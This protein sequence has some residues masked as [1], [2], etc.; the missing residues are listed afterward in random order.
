MKRVAALCLVFSFLSFAQAGIRAYNQNVDVEQFDRAMIADHGATFSHDWG[1]GIDYPVRNRNLIVCLCIC[2]FL[3]TALM[4]RSLT[5]LLLLLGVYG[6][7]ILLIY[8]WITI[9]LRDLSLNPYYMADSP[10]LLRVASTFDW[11][12]FAGLALAVI[13]V[14]TNFV[15]YL[16]GVKSPDRIV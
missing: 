2:G 6:L 15:F 16:A 13:V 10:Y 7:T 14:G 4:R 5:S 1:W 12:L 9:T 3:I 8:Q 11:L